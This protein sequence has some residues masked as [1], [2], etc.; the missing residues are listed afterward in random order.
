MTDNF[1][2]SGAFSRSEDTNEIP[3]KSDMSDVILDG[4]PEITE[5]QSEKTKKGLLDNPNTAKW[6]FD[7]DSLTENVQKALN[8]EYEKQSNERE[9][10]LNRKQYMDK[11]GEMG[12]G[13]LAQL[14]S[15]LGFNNM[16]E[17]HKKLDSMSGQELYGVLSPTTKTEFTLE[18]LQSLGALASGFDF[19]LEDVKSGRIE[20]GSQK[21][22]DVV[23]Y[24]IKG[25]TELRRSRE[26]SDALNRTKKHL[27]TPKIQEYNFELGKL[28]ALP[29]IFDD[30]KITLSEE[31]SIELHKLLSLISE[32]GEYDD[33]QLLNSGKTEYQEA[34][35]KVNATIENYL[36]THTPLAIEKFSP[37][38]VGRRFSQRNELPSPTPIIENETVEPTSPNT[39][40]PDERL[41]QVHRESLPTD[42]MMETIRENT[43]MSVDKIA[44][45]RLDDL[46]YF[47]TDKSQQIYGTEVGR[48]KIKIDKI[49]K[50]V[51]FIEVPDLYHNEARQYTTNQGEK[52]LAKFGMII[53]K[54]S[55]GETIGIDYFCPGDEKRDGYGFVRPND[56][57]GRLEGY[58]LM[59]I[60]EKGE[61]RIVNNNYGS[62]QLLAGKQDAYNGAEV[63]YYSA[64]NQFSKDIDPSRETGNP[65]PKELYRGVVAN[66][67][68]MLQGI[69]IALKKFTRE[70]P[71]FVAGEEKDSGVL[72]SRLL[73]LSLFPAKERNEGV[74]AS[75]NPDVASIYIAD[76]TRTAEGREGSEQGQY[77]IV[78][79]IANSEGMSFRHE[80]W[81]DASS[82]NYVSD[83]FDILSPLLADGN[84]LD[85]LKNVTI[86]SITTP[87]GNT[88]FAGSED[89]N[90]VAKQLLEEAQKNS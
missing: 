49:D 12:F 69:N 47:T 20:M 40:L 16:Q 29:L 52:R 8:D 87:N 21:P 35:D 64:L 44:A 45:T 58:F 90:S 65:E 78:F 61:L 71:G 67:E 14:G 63:G 5:E 76:R 89:F 27:R 39:L 66:K 83:K 79:K 81:R 59:K 9:H 46:E 26:F 13:E 54:I 50:M 88:Y 28:K 77:G 10:D 48:I 86:E 62:E 24:I 73:A 57:T 31:Q 72:L 1:E 53:S 19:T 43:E 33:H 15:Q 75:T 17:M 84:T 70:Q 42:L 36:A 18:D 32:K 11:I 23:Q 55:D 74:F 6:R 80:Q 37:I 41:T 60:S 51:Q 34:Q 2:T 22:Q 68:K 30:E 85:L 82:D 7:F 56:G 25:E 3:I 4:E 38:L